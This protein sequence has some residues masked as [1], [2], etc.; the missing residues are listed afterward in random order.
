YA[1]PNVRAV[2]LASKNGGKPYGANLENVISENYPLGR[3]L[4]IYVNRPSGKPLDPLVRE[5]CR[6]VFSREGQEVVVKDGYLPLP[7][8]VA[9]KELK[10][11]E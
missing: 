7:L 10:L 9:R 3:Y 4:N 8:E 5:F 11:L 2:P 6:F 1:T